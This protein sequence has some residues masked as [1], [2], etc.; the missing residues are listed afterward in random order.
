MYL[1]KDLYWTMLDDTFKSRRTLSHCS[2]IVFISKLT[3]LY[4]CVL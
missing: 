4:V 1:V 3:H 2:C